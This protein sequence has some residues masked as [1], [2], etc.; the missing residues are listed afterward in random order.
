MSKRIRKKR[1]TQLRHQPYLA[2][3]INYDLEPGDDRRL[4]SPFYDGMCVIV[5]GEIEQMP[6]HV[7]VATPDGKVHYGWG[8][9]YFWKIPR[10]DA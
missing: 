10:E 5:L 4:N 2:K 3:V 9:E 8:I 1:L 6:G 7:A